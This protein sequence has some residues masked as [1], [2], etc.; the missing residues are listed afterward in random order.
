MSI[1]VLSQYPFSPEFRSRLEHRV[2]RVSEYI[3]LAELRDLPKVALWKRLRSLRPERLVIPL[4][5]ENSGVV[6][7]FLKLVAAMSSAKQ[8]EIVLP[9]LTAARARRT[10]FIRDLGA[11]I[12][13]SGR[14][15][16]AA[17]ATRREAQLLLKEPRARTQVGRSN[18]V[19]FINA[20]LWFGV[21]AG[22]SVGHIAGVANGLRGAGYNVDYCSPSENPLLKENDVNLVQLEPP[23]SFGFPPEYTH[24]LFDKSATAQLLRLASTD[25]AFI[26]QRLSLANFTG[27][28]IARHLN[29][30]YVVEYNGSEAWIA[31]NWGRPLQDHQLAVAAEEVCLKH[32]TV[33]VTISKV[34]KDEL[35][36]RGVEEKRIACYPNCVNERSFDASRFAQKELTELRASFGI[37]HDALVVGFVGTFGAWHGVEIMAEA[38]RTLSVEAP[39]WLRQ[40]KVH[41]LLIGDGQKMPAVKEILGG[42]KSEFW[43]LAGL[44]PQAETPR[45]L[46]AT[47]ILLS[48]HVTNKDGSRFFG[49]PTKLFEYM[50]MGKAIVA[51]DLGQIGEVLNNSLRADDLPA[52]DCPGAD[53]RVAVLCRPGAVEELMHGLR[54]LVEHPGWRLRLGLN[55]RNEALLKYTWTSHVARILETLEAVQGS[56]KC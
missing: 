37:A 10:S 54:F 48:P 7:P 14:G 35:I 5:D 29:L 53:S 49:S 20:N 47:D 3:S 30:P 32:A 56:G 13:A 42:A 6:L 24:Y 8:I 17:A 19:M 28:R 55:A 11:V 25:Y 39:G 38:M 4:E 22:G 1:G 40:Y 36:S 45:H 52:G 9:D 23:R 41:F 33:V 46:A 50:A 12:G 18:K 44:I 21:K 27:V 26:Y 16:I 15:R 51:S 2:G 34:L 43:T 31:K